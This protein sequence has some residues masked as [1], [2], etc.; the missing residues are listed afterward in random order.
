[1]Y[2]IWASITPN[3]SRTAAAKVKVVLEAPETADVVPVMAV[4]VVVGVFI[5]DGVVSEV[6]VVEVVVSEVVVASADVTVGPP[7]VACCPGLGVGV[8]A[9]WSTAVLRANPT[10]VN[11]SSLGAVAHH[12]IELDACWPTL[13]HVAASSSLLEHSVVMLAHPDAS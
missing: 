7:S 4:S 6:V 13:H 1:M 2:T 9:A 5:T 11:K 8:A 12:S 10:D 3:S